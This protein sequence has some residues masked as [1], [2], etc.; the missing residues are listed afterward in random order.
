[1]G[2]FQV[3]DRVLV[4]K[5]E[6][7]GIDVYP[8]WVPEMDKYDGTEVIVRSVSDEAWFSDQWQ[9]SDDWAYLIERAGSDDLSASIPVSDV[10]PHDLAPTL[11]DQFAMAA[12]T[13]L[14][15]NSECATNGMEPTISYLAHNQDGSWLAKT[16]FVI[17]DAM[18][19]ARAK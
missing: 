16:A 10:I 15:S 2:K 1:M 4:R 6:G 18:L 12:L 14:I 11:R 9:F 7:A 13:G 5:P 19:A 17:A 3:G 8:Y